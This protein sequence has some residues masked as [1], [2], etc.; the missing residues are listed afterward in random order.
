MNKAS[1]LKRWTIFSALFFWGAISFVFI[2]SEEAPD[3]LSVSLTKF[4]FREVIGIVSLVL[5]FFA[6]RYLNREGLL[7]DA[8]EED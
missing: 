5:C 2:A 8:T 6:G 4:F 3:G 7:P 1:N